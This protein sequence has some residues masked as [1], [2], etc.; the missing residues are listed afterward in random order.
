MWPS[1][2][3]DEALQ[4][5]MLGNARYIRNE[6]D[7]RDFSKS[8][9]LCIDAQQPIAA[10][11]GCADSRVVPEFIFDQ[12]LGDLF[13]T[14]VAGNVASD[15]AI[16]SLEF[17]AAILNVPVIL[18]LGH[19][20]CAAVDAALQNTSVPGHLPGL[21]DQ[22]QVALDVRHSL[23]ENVAAHVKATVEQLTM[24]SFVLANCVSEGRASV[25]GAMYDMVSG[26]VQILD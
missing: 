10:I 23:A 15:E 17:A 11:L 18:V 2:S 19:S 8:R 7:G 14:R 4:T 12:G 26:E 20:N 9:E 16:A 13:V 21:I 22:I 5:L 6:L 3:P 24:K 1:L 25:V